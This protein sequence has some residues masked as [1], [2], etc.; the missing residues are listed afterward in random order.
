ML[1]RLFRNKIDD[2]N[3]YRRVR[4][5]VQ[6]GMG[7]YVLDRKYDITG[8]IRRKRAVFDPN[9]AVAFF[10]LYPRDKTLGERLGRFFKIKGIGKPYSVGQNI[11]TAD[12]SRKS[13]IVIDLRK[14][15]GADV[16][17]II[18][19]LRRMIDADVL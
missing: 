3:G 16:F 11:K 15:E 17:V 5:A 18:Q 12:K 13:R 2:I 10:G 9:A 8:K 7:Q 1:R 19:K 6:Y 4:V 14:L